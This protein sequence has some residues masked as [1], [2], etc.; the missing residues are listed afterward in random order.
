MYGAWDGDISNNLTNKLEQA[1]KMDFSF[2]NR[3]LSSLYLFVPHYLIY[4]LMAKI[5]VIRNAP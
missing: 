1:F 2:T 3:Y 4:F 5:S